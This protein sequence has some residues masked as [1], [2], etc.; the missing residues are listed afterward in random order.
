M[1]RVGR[2][3]ESARLKG[4]RYEGKT[5][6]KSKGCRAKEP[7]ATFKPK[8]TPGCRGGYVLRTAV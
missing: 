1:L 6:F 8:P 4:D 7:G 2:A 3:I 5:K